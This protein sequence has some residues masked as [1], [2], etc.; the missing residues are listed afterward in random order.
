M[1]RIA[2]RVIVFVLPALLAGLSH[3]Q[4][5]EP[6]KQ[7]YP[8]PAWLDEG[9]I[10]AGMQS[11]DAT[12][13]LARSGREPRTWF[14]EDWANWTSEAQVKQWKQDGITLMILNFYR[15]FG[16]GIEKPQLDDTIDPALHPE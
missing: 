1:L 2:G 3:A 13:M 5:I 15:G 8:R 16:L 4:G 12:L 11:C 10:V 7:R 9:P 14:K 6:Y